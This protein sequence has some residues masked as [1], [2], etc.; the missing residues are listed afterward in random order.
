MID[1]IPGEVVLAFSEHWNESTHD[2]IQ[3]DRSHV[4][5]QE[6]IDNAHAIID[7][8]RAQVACMEI[9]IDRYR[10]MAEGLYHQRAAFEADLARVT[11]ER[12]WLLQRFNIRMPY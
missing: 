3:A 7:D 11:A 12:D 5:S 9:E 8:L 2:K 1:W 10:G 4:H 6:V